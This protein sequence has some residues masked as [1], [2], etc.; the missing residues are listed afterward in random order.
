M[1][2]HQHETFLNLDKQYTRK[3]KLLTK[4][5]N[6]HLN[7]Y[8]FLTYFILSLSKGH[9]LYLSICDLILLPTF[10]ILGYGVNMT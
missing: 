2:K 8:Y 9:S 5:M 4:S 3:L 6:I 7:I 10:I 1:I